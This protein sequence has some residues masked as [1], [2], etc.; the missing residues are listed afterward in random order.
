MIWS[1]FSDI[2]TLITPLHYYF[3]ALIVLILPTPLHLSLIYPLQYGHSNPIRF[4]CIHIN[5]LWFDNICSFSPAL[6]NLIY[7]LNPLSVHIC[8][9]KS[10]SI[11]SPFSHDWYALKWFIRLYWLILSYIFLSCIGSVFIGLY[12]IGSDPLE[13]F[14]IKSYQISLYMYFTLQYIVI[15]L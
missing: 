6:I 2:S 1:L 3:Y 9:L 14:H 12:W 5:S 8:L 7:F 15:L 10:F 11:L 4:I 13:L